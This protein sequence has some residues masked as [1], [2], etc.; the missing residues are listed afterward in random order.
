MFDIH[1]LDLWNKADLVVTKT[2]STPKDCTRSV[3]RTDFVRYHFNGTL[4]DGSVFDSST[5]REPLEV[6]MGEGV[7]IPGF[8]AALEGR[9]KG[10]KFTIKISADNAYGEHLDD[11]VVKVPRENLSHDI[12]PEIGMGLNIPTDSGDIEVQIVGIDDDMLILDANHPFAGK[13]LTFSVEIIDVM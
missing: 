7:V 12:T 9:V 4:L 2:I 5:D 1:L 11:L 3:M 13:D 6:N 10:E 8:E